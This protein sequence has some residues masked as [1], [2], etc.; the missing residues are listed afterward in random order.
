[1]PTLADK[2]PWDD[3]AA[4]VAELYRP[5][6]PGDGNDEAEIAAAETRLGLKLP[7]VLREFYLLA[8]RRDDIHRARNHLIHPEDLAVEQGVLVI[9]EE[10]QNVVLWGIKIEAL[11]HDDPPIVRAYNDVTLSWEADHDRLSTF[12]ATML[13]WQAVNGGLPF[14]GVVVHIDETELPE[15]QSHWPRV[16]LLGTLWNHL[17]VFHRGGQVICI[18]G[19]SPA[20]SL[21]AAGRTKGDLDT[22]TRRL[23]LDWDEPAAVDED[24]SAIV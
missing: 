22:I 21:H 14:A 8:G 12:L 15:I 5:L 3:Y 13:Y 2:A 20:L 16:D 23:K 4:R 10:N 18:N 17:I 1:M 7:R 9:Y 11:G 19:H 24:D 6:A